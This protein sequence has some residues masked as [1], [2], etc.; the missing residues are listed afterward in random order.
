MSARHPINSASSQFTYDALDRLIQASNAVSDV[1]LAYDAVGQLLAETQTLAR[2]LRHSVR[3]EFKHEYDALGNRTQTVLPG[4]RCAGSP[5]LWLGPPA[6]NQHRRAVGQQLRARCTVPRSETVAGST[7]SKE[8]GYNRASQLEYPEGR[9]TAAD[10][11]GT[12]ATPGAS[13]S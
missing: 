12:V 6:S 1:Q 4:G 8:F 7:L 2:F 9:C 3:I 11:D 13:P 5:V 10:P